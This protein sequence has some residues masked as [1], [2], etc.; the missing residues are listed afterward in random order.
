[1]KTG[2]LFV[3]SIA[4]FYSSAIAQRTDKKLQ[5]QIAL[6]IQNFHGC[7]GVYVHDLNKNKF[8]AIN[9]DTIFPTAS[10]IKIPILVGIMDKLH[11]GELQYHGN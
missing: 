11:K 8:V 3:L 2:F 10:T 6:L 9:A 4:L 7:I 5:Q 1:M